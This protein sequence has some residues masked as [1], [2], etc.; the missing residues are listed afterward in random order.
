VVGSAEPGDRIA[1]HRAS[2]DSGV[3]STVIANLAAHGHMDSVEVD[4]VTL[5]QI[6]A[7]YAGEARWP[8]FLSIDVEGRDVEILHTVEAAAVKVICIEAISQIGDVSAGIRAWA[9]ANGFAVHS[10]WGGN[11]LLVNNADVS[12]LC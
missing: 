2:H 11:M 10:W 7:W 8:D 3:N 1:L 9:V 6:V 12:R 4:A 5:P